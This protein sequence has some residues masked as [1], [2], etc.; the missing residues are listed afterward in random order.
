MKFVKTIFLI[1]MTMLSM[2]LSINSYAARS[3]VPLVNHEK[4]QIVT[5]INK[6][7]TSDLIK[8]AIRAG[9]AVR[10]WKVEESA[11]G[12]MLATIVIRKHTA[13]VRINYDT[14]KYSIHYKD[15]AVLKYEVNNGQAIIH[16]FYNKWVENL[17][18]DINIQLL[19]L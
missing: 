7:P 13:V 1:C 15:S 9:A 17:R 8:Q 5:G 11:E 16:P 18:D 12:S 6:A 3:A 2:L 19:K 4:I 14:S 10:G